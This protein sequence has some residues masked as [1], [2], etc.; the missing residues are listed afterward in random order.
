MKKSNE[1]IIQSAAK[2]F[3]YEELEEEVLSVC[4]GLND[5]IAIMSSLVAILKK[6]IDYYFWVGFYRNI[7]TDQ[8][9]IGPY[10]GS[11]ACLYIPFNK[12]VCGKAARTLE[13]QIV[14]DVNSFPGHIAC[15][16]RSKSEIVV[17]W[18]DK[19]GKLIAVLDVDSDNYSSF[20]NE[21]KKGLERIL[22]KLSNL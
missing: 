15:D 17:P 3:T 9:L 11:L 19:D 16:A 1:E 8:L 5:Q 4:S 21:D 12:G 7:G 20:C 18:L 22:T 10:Q 13:T 2:A 6:G 14:D